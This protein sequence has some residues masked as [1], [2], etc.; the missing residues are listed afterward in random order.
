MAPDRAHEWRES[1]EYQPDQY[2]HHGKGHDEWRFHFSRHGLVCDV[3]V[4]HWPSGNWG[5]QSLLDA[6]GLG[7]KDPPPPTHIDNV[8][9][10][11]RGPP[12]LSPIARIGGAFPD[13][14]LPKTLEMAL[15][16]I[17]NYYFEAEKD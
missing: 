11:T 17:D 9:R 1:T 14:S 3:T 12:R 5:W 13:L 7:L 10:R 16:Q 8:R 15:Q 4:T 6:R 2:D